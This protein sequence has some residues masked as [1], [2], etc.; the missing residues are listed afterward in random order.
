M[1]VHLGADKGS[2]LTF[3]E[4]LIFV[5]RLTVISRI[6]SNAKPHATCHNELFEGLTHSWLR[7]PATSVQTVS[8]SSFNVCK[9]KILSSGSSSARKA[10]M[11]WAE[12]S[13]PGIFVAVVVVVVP[14]GK[15]RDDCAESGQEWVNVKKTEEKKTEV[16][17]RLFGRD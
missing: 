4:G 15:D 3:G 2:Q 9:A 12:V 14:G 10:K 17:L 7:D 1:V 13:K 5:E 16:E 8:I 11:P 6:V